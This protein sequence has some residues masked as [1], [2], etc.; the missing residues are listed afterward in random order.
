[1]SKRGSMKQGDKLRQYSQYKSRRQMLKYGTT[2]GLL[3]ALAGCSGS[4]ENPNSG[5]GGGGS[6]GDSGANSDGNGN[7]DQP[8][9]SL[10]APVIGF[11]SEEPIGQSYMEEYG[12]DLT[13]RNISA[14]PVELIQL[15]SAGNG[16]AEFDGVWANGGGM[17]DLMYGEDMIVEVDSNEIG[18]WDNIRSEYEEGGT[19]RSTL[20]SDGNLVGSPSSQNCDSVA[21]NRDVVEDVNSWGV[22]Y[23]EEWQGRTAV[24]DDYANTPH[25]TAMYLDQNNMADIQGET[26]DPTPYS[27]LRPEEL[28][29]VIDFLVDKKQAGQFQT[30]WASFGNIVQQLI[31]GEIVA[32]YAYEPSVIQ[33]RDQGGNIGYPA[34]KEGNW[35][36]NDHWFM[37][38]GCTDRGRQEQFYQLAEWALSP[39]VGARLHETRGYESGCNRDLVV[40]YM[41]ENWEEERVQD[42]LD[43]MEARQERYDANGDVMAWNNPNPTNLDLYLEEWNRFLSA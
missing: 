18:N 38:Q 19:Y 12:V 20:E 7:G 14:Q 5:D 36:W 21:H 4:P 31:S 25:H 29:T 3:A 32:T 41:E 16:Q 30:I 42:N 8:E 10:A 23:D 28:E 15:F 27:D 40:E 39:E 1:M 43:S 22:V 35:E 11:P 34:L 33:A 9:L 24:L 6:D 2:G 26:S 37:T 17:E 13:H